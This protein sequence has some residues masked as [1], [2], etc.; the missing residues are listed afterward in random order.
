MNYMPESWVILT[1]LFVFNFALNYQTSHLEKD[2]ALIKKAILDYYHEGHVKSDPELYKRIL[3]DEW[4]FFLFDKE[5]RLR[6]VDK[7][8]YI[9]WSDPSKADPA[10]GWKTDIFYIDVTGKVGAAKI[11][12]ESNKVIYID[13]FNLMKIDGKWWIVHK[14]SHGEKKKI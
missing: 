9:S 14:L 2:K 7:N 12:L 6:I 8:E 5:G 10:L 4:K 3:H 1:L 11:K 13:Y